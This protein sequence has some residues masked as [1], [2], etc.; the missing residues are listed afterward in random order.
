[1]PGFKRTCAGNTGLLLGGLNKVK[2]LR[3]NL[4]PN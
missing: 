2:S 4:S 3:L 1:M